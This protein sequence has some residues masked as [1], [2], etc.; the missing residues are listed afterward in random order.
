MTEYRI[1]RHFNDNVEYLQYLKIEKKLFFKK[2]FWADVPKA[3]R[4][5][6]YYDLLRGYSISIKDKTINS[7]NENLNLFVQKY[8]DINDY[9]TNYKKEQDRFDKEVNLE[10][11]RLHE[12]LHNSI[13]Q[14]FN[15]YNDTYDMAIKRQIK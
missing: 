4:D 13:I 9:L 10:D 3:Y 14:S 7:E 11:M 12:K 2:T 15:N 1:I 5:Y 6:N 8:C